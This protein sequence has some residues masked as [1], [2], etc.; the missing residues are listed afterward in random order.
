ME[1]LKDPLKKEILN[2]IEGDVFI[3]SQGEYSDLC[4]GPHVWSTSCVGKG[5]K[6]IAVSEITWKNHKLQRIE[7]FG[8][9]NLEELQRFEKEYEEKKNNDH[10][11]LGKDLD[12]FSVSEYSSGMAFW[13]PKGL[14][15]FRKIEDFIRKIKH[16]Y[17]EICTPPIYKSE[18]WKRTGH[19]DKYRENMFVIDQKDHNDS[20][21]DQNDKN[22]N[23]L[24]LKPMNCPAHTLFFKT[25][26][27]SYRDL[28]LRIAEFGRVFRNEDQGGIIGLKRSKYFCQDD[29]HIFLMI[30]QLENEIVSLLETVDK[31]YKRFNYENY[32]IK[33]ATRPEKRIGS[34]ESWNIA[35]ESL[36][37]AVKK[38][39]KEYLIVEGD[40]AFYGPKIEFHL[41]DNFGKTWQCGT[42]QV[43]FFLSERLDASFT[44]SNGKLENPV[45]IHVAVLGSIERFIAVLL[46]KEKLPFWLNP[47]QLMIV[48]IGE[49]QLEYCEKIKEKLSEYEVEIIYKD[50]KIGEKLK[51]CYLQKPSL[52]GIVGKN[53][54]E[55]NTI[56]IQNKNEKTEVK[57]DDLIE[58][59][60][61][62][63][64]I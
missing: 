32:L 3:Y 48:P 64:K 35:E 7:G 31:V 49:N 51:H 28:P 60:K 12:I 36:I 38:F 40:G 27:R 33:I 43:D 59:M 23:S 46:E 22:D 47:N 29:T 25:K 4:E 52:I 2:N 26:S 57:L 11:Q 42:I 19:W 5:F 55:N 45:V 56:T 50:G 14:K 62:F 9:H 1:L 13:H 20:Q 15:L 44:N 61:S 39:N 8:F 37:N 58:F 41:S 16:N 24:V 17:L 30:E 10:R 53:E 21:K 18:L 63:E 6:L 34:D 54:M